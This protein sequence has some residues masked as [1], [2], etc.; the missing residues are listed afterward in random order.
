MSAHDDFVKM[1]SEDIKNGERLSGKKPVQEQQAPAQQAEGVQKG[2]PVIQDFAKLA[3]R[4]LTNWN[5]QRKE[6]PI[7]E[8][9][10]KPVRVEENKD[11]LDKAFEQSMA[12]SSEK[13]EL[14]EKIIDDFKNEAGKEAEDV[15]AKMLKGI[16]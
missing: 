4:D 10:D 5:G 13:E 11:E 12:P 6:E 3:A 1:V 15:L 9:Q 7:A 16:R 14:K 2:S 8:A